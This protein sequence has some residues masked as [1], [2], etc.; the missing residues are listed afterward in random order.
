MGIYIYTY[1]NRYTDIYAHHRKEQ[2][3]IDATNV[4]RE[5][6]LSKLPKP[7]PDLNYLNYLNQQPIYQGRAGGNRR[8]KRRARASNQRPGRAEAHPPT[9][10]QS[11]RTGGEAR[12]ISLLLASLNQQTKPTSKT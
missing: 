8:D 6:A 10:R 3:A 12:R 7:M 2:E 4:G 11:A 9:A 5:Q 1:I